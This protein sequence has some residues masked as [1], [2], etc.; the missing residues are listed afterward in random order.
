[1]KKIYL[2][3]ISYFLILAPLN[4]G[5]SGFVITHDVFG[6]I[7]YYFSFKETTDY[8]WEKE[9]DK[10]LSDDKFLTNVTL[11]DL[12][13]YY[14]INKGLINLD[15]ER[16]CSY[17]KGHVM[18]VRYNAGKNKYK[19]AISYREDKISALR[20]ALEKL[21]ISE[22][23][24]FE[25]VFEDTFDATKE[26]QTIKGLTRAKYEIGSEKYGIRNFNL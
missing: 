8:N 24:D 1:M 16:R 11:R 22:C 15:G 26:K 2:I 4:A 18:I 9:T 23:D 7:G 5:G 6:I 25:I 20:R 21:E 12:E 17:N 10:M 14:P 19:F 13:R 3:L